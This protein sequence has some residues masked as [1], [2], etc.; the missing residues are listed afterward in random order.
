MPELTIGLIEIVLLLFSITV[1]EFFH[2]YIAEKFGDDTARLMGRL[3]LNPLAH[4][5][6]FGTILLPLLAII[7]HM[8]VFGWAKPVPVDPYKLNNPKRDMMFVGIA[9]PLSNFGVAVGSSFC[10]WIL[11]SFSVFLYLIPVFNYL[12]TINIILAVFNLIPIPPLDGSQILKGI[13]PARISYEYDKLIPFGFLI[14][15]F[16]LT[17]GLLWYIL[18]PVVS[19]LI[20]WLGVGPS[21]LII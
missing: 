17:S 16:L 9:G 13:L 8:P 10:L 1:H 12:L 21:A 6:L 3:T 7:T 19:Y 2:G 15:L 14:I 4:I 18:G 20:R 5:D 11:K